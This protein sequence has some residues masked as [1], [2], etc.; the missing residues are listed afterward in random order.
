[1]LLEQFREQAARVFLGAYR[2]TLESAVNPWVK[3][4]AE[5]PLLDLFL[6]E[7]AAYEVRYEIANRPA[8]LRI[9]LR[10]LSDIAARLLVM[11]EV[12]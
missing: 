6:I 7:K 12:A 4:S 11:G 9:P 5:T 10:G 3:A 8:W 1:M 2:A